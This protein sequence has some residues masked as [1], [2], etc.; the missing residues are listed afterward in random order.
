M[1]KKIIWL[2]QSN[3]VTSTLYD[4][5]K[6]MKKRMEN[7]IDFIFII[8]QTSPEMVERLS[9]LDPLIFETSL[10][11]AQPSYQAYLAKRAVL[12]QKLP[13][14]LGIA[15]AL[16]LDDLAGGH[17]ARTAI[18]I[19]VHEETCG[20]IMQ[21]PTP[22]GSSAI[23]ERIFHAAVLWAREHRLPA[24]GYELLPLDTRWTL[25][26]SI[27]DGIIT[28]SRDSYAHLKTELDN[29]QTWCLPRYEAAMFSPTA[30]SFNANGLKSTYH[31]K[32][33][34][35][36]PPDRTILFVPHNVAMIYEY[37]QLIDWLGPAGKNLHLMFSYGDDQ[38][39]GAHTQEEIVEIIYKKELSRIASHSFHNI[40]APWEMMAADGLAACS[41]CFQTQIAGDKNIPCIILDPFLPPQ[42]QENRLRVDSQKTLLE[43]VEKV[44]EEKNKTTEMG[45]ILIHMAAGKPN[46]K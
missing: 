11:K 14:G 13:G 46:E 38:V 28:R 8:P 12:D 23:E 45:E 1:K 20:I 3:Q 41:S 26:A 27:M 40:N 17:L 10:K 5:M 29:I 22:L 16:L 31:Y 43:A 18:D 7:F 39:R 9:D 15:D 6:T 30:T 34:L 35:S 24:V 19:P 32:G 25:A 2:V 4:F 44:I 42:S 33:T 21:I 37:R 36:I